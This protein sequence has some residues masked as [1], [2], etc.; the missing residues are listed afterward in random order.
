ML[1]RDH[2][3]RAAELI[4]YNGRVVPRLTKLPQQPLDGL[5]FGHEAN[6][7]EKLAEIRLRPEQHL[8][9]E[10]HSH[11]IVHR[12]LVGRDV[13][14]VGLLDKRAEGVPPRR[15]VEHRQ[16]HA[17][18]HD[19]AQADARDLDDLLHHAARVAVQSPVM[20]GHRHER[21]QFLPGHIRS[22]ARVRRQNTG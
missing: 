12:A 15:E 11:H 8:A 3:G 5:R 1:Q 9:A 4:H 21:L 2:P 6:R 13:I 17:R 14:L 20:L 22:R 16:V 19:L 7:A 10:K 18:R